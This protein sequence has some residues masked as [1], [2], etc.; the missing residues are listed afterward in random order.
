MSPAI[1]LR[2]IREPMHA[3]ESNSSAHWNSSIVYSVVNFYVAYRE[4]SGWNLIAILTYKSF[5]M[6]GIRAVNY[7]LSSVGSSAYRGNDG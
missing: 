4:N 6:F 2:E 1:E 3:P 7:Q 5:V